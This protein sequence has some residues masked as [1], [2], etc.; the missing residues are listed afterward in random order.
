MMPIRT[1]RSTAGRALRH[2]R[3]PAAARAE[4]AADRRPPTGADPGPEVALRACLDWLR[5]AQ[6]R[7]T[8]RDGGVARH[9]SLVSGWG[10]SYPETTGYIAPTVLSAGDRLADPDLTDRG[11]RMLDWLVSIQFR[12]GG[13]QGGMVNQQPVVP[14]TFN[15]GQ[16]LMGLADGARRWPDAYAEPMRAA[17][18]W[19]TDTQ[20]SDGC[21]RRHPTPFARPGEKAYETHVAWGLME[22]VRTE[23][24]AAWRAAALRNV[25]WALTHQ[26]DNGWFDRCCLTDAAHPLTHT[27]GY[28]LRGVVE[29]WRLS[30]D[31]RY[32]EAAV[33]TADGLLTARRPD[34]ALPGR[35]GR[36]W[37]GHVAWSCL[38]GNVQIAACWLL[39]HGDTGSPEYREAAIAANAFVRRT[40]RLDG[41]TGTRG[42]VKGSYPV[43]GA[44]GRYEYLNWAAKFAV[45]AFLMEMDTAE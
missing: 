44:Y 10:A 20:D 4:H 35:L 36:D 27:L 13:F 3:L 16:I 2:L 31:S 29:A 18:D 15:T 12:E 39:L 23:E 38:T 14:V 26:A 33:R 9:Y 5:E 21:W 41:P 24:N 34:G 6:D 45:D 22:A 1:L 28:V 19:L 40:I 43:S 8:T 42:G 25:D 11:R 17:A 30:G 7:S 32:L 37:A